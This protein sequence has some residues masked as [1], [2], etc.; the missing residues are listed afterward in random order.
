MMEP[1][2]YDDEPSEDEFVT[3]NVCG[4]QV[5]DCNFDRHLR[6]VHPNPTVK[7]YYCPNYMP[8]KHLKAH[9]ERKH[10][11]KKCPHCSEIGSENEIKQHQFTHFTM[12]IYCRNT[13]LEKNLNAHVLEKH[14]LQATIGMIQLEK[15]GN[16][17]FNR[18]VNEKRIYSK[19]GHLYI[20]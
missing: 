7:C 4:A 3:C 17:Q 5:L 6:R 14:P 19:D 12:C 1:F 16:D 2:Y 9:I 18:L 11:N 13:F 8:K 20:K 15:I 10:T